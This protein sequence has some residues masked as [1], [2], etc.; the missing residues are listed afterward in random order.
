MQVIKTVLLFSFLVFAAC[1]QDP[2]SAAKAPGTQDPSTTGA[3]VKPEV[4]LY[5]VTV[6]NLQLRDQP[7]L[8]GSNVI[9]KFSEGSFVTGTGEKSTNKVEVDLRGIPYTDHFYKVTGTTPQQHTGW[10][11]GGALL[12]VYAGSNSGSPDLGKLTQLSSFLKALNTK[13]LKSGKKAWD[14]V[15]ANFADV[16]GA[17]A[18]ATY[19]LLSQFV[20]RMEYEGEFYV[21]AEKISWKQEDYDAISDDKFDMN[22]YPLTQSFAENGFRLETGE[23]M[24]YPIADWQRFYDFFGSKVTPVLNAYLGQ[25]LAERKAL[26]SDDGGLMIPLSEMANRA[27]FW[28][29]FNKE[30]PHFVMAD[31]AKTSEQW[32][33][34]VVITGMDNTPM[35]NGE[36]KDINQEFKDTWTA[37]LQKYPGTLLAQKCKEITDI[38]VANGWK[39]TEKVEVWS[40]DFVEKNAQ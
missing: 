32:M 12:P 23:G 19:I 7:A 9:T 30:N 22:K 38:C 3:P 36:S 34:A 40:R 18:D 28:E 2:K 31:R 26:D 11:F 20:S 37:V 14:Y 17:L 21:M 4:I 1:K 8:T 39:Y 24:V 27:V 16:K 15:A 10:A 25:D 6:D 33:R 29:K 5:A 35:F 13:D